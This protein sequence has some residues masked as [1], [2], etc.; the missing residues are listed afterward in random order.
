MTPQININAVLV[1][2]FTIACIISISL[3]QPVPNVRTNT[4]SETILHSEYNYRNA[5]INT[6]QSL[7]QTIIHLIQNKYNYMDS[8][9]DRLN[10]DSL[11][12]HYRPTVNIPRGLEKFER[13]SEPYISSIKHFPINQTCKLPNNISFSI[14]NTIGAGNQGTTFNVNINISR[15]YTSYVLKLFGKHNIRRF[16]REEYTILKMIQ[17]YCTY[18]N[19]SNSLINI[20]FVHPSIPGY[21]IPSLSWRKS[22]HFFFIKT[23]SNAIDWK[24]FMNYKELVP[25]S[26][27]KSCYNDIMNVLHVLYDINVFHNDFMES[28]IL[29][30]KVTKK[31][32]LIDFGKMFY[33]IN[34]NQKRNYRYKC[35]TN[36]CSP[37]AYSY[38]SNEQRRKIFVNYYNENKLDEIYG[39]KPFDVLNE[40]A[41][42]DK[43]YQITSM[44]LQGFIQ[45][46]Y[47]K[48]STLSRMNN[49]IYQLRGT[50]KD[51]PNTWCKRLKIL[52]ILRK[53]E[54]KISDEFWK[55]LSI[56]QNDLMFIN[57]ITC[58]LHPIYN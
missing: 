46:N 57:P 28:N 19:I 11:K 10:T 25:N 22:K 43:Q 23:I 52:E 16:A 58:Y 21:Y 39:K 33:K 8:C 12:Y 7:P 30:N 14:L 31:C 47:P 15:K 34:K 42:Y 3:I 56:F 29:I 41:M 37:L 13:L 1:V 54:N 45:L 20:P 32:Y 36:T 4:L 17:T 44:I 48:N 2:M 51:M 27:F 53:D 49:E 6:N 9:I 38:L 26:F 18:F 24:T 5:S 55:L 50:V 35:R 40:F